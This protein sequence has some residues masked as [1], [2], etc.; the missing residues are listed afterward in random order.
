M[1]LLTLYLIA[2]I[3]NLGSTLGTMFWV[4]L[5]AFIPVFIVG[6]CIYDK[7]T[8]ATDKTK[9]LVIK[10]VKYHLITFALIVFLGIFVPSTKQMAF[11]FVGSQLTNS[12]TI[13]ELGKTSSKAA[14]FMNL[15][16]DKELGLMREELGVVAEEVKTTVVNKV[17]GK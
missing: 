7:N 11:I 13:A 1:D 8:E 6:L 5:A 15:Y 9:N 2:I 12:N 10:W 17:K 14:E 3:P 16:I 4:L